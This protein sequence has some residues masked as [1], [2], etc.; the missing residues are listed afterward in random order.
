[1]TLCKYVYE[2]TRNIGQQFILNSWIIERYK[3][4][5]STGLLKLKWPADLNVWSTQLLKEEDL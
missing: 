4:N 3:E 1:M 2:N 5:L